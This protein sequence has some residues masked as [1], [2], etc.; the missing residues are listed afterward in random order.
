MLSV[1]PAVNERWIGRTFMPFTAKIIPNV[2]KIRPTA[3]KRMVSPN[4]MLMIPKA[5]VMPDS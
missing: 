3:E 4:T 1:S 2:P 5:I